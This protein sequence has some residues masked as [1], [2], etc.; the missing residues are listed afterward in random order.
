[1]PQI[2]PDITY[3]GGGT[4]LFVPLGG[5]GSVTIP[6]NLAVTGTL[7][8]AGSAVTFNG[9]TTVTRAAAGVD[10]Y[11]KVLN[12]GGEGIGIRAYDPAGGQPNGT[13][14]LQT[15]INS[16]TNSTGGLVFDPAG[17]VSIPDQKSMTAALFNLAGAPAA[18]V[19]G[20]A[21]ITGAGNLVVANTGIT[22]G[23]IIMV[24]PQSA[25]AVAEPLRVTVTPATGFTIFNDNAGAVTAMYA[26]LSLDGAV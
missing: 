9:T 8:T 16:T 23:S 11:L 22:A 26:V 18:G 17:N 20:K 7:T 12:N 2:Q 6:G 13:V 3:T 19:Y 24:T 10:G 1:M 21:T 15:V 14:A 5:N 4:P 25:S